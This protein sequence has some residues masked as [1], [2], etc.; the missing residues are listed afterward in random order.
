MPQVDRALID[1]LIAAFDP[2]RGALV[3]VP[4]IDGRRG[5][6]VVWS[7]RFFPDLMAIT[8]DIGARHLIASYA[9]AVV[10][11]PVVGAGRAHRCR[12]AGRAVR[13]QGRARTRKRVTR[14]RGAPARLAR[15]SIAWGA[16]LRSLKIILAVL[17]LCG[18][19]AADRQRGQGGGRDCD[20]QMHARRLFLRL[21]VARRGRTARAFRVPGQR[22]PQLPRGGDHPPLVRRLRGFRRVRR[23]RLGLR[24]DAWP[25]RDHRAQ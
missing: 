14:S 22:R 1:K 21:S 5:N 10:E 18:L 19:M 2:E 9:E 12:Y 6:P 20:R 13:A 23:A 8:G 17:A 11:V 25:R 4:S 7:R 3:V 24:P 15:G 16:T